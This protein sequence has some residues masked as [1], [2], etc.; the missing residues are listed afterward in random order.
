[1][2]QIDKQINKKEPKGQ[3]KKGKILL[4]FNKIGKGCVL[5]KSRNT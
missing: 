4:S 3:K 5:D 1:M 2:K